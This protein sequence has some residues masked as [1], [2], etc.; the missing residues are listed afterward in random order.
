MSILR[1]VLKN[2]FANAI[3][4]VIRVVEQLVMIP[5]FIQ[6]WGA[7]YY[8][9]WITLTIVPSLIFMA[10]LGFGTSIANCFVLKYS[11]GLAKEA[12]DTWK[13]G[14]RTIHYVVTVGVISTTSIVYL[15]YH[16][17]L[18][19]KALI[20]SREAVWALII[21]M[22]TRFIGFYLQIYEGFFRAV[23]KSAVGI[24][25]LNVYSFSTIL[26]SIIILKSEK[27]IIYL[28]SMGFVI[29]LV[30]L[31]IYVFQARKVIPEKL[32][33]IIL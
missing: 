9:E 29:M 32:K 5:F 20:D 16:F 3:Q 8:G 12:A 15:V 21:M 30:F 25:L 18:L 14:I 4:K 19:E 7:E 27:G 22:T 6:A 26:S 1:N 13:T 10:D 31:V 33:K 17:G 28:A 24:N 2:G 23:R 11:S